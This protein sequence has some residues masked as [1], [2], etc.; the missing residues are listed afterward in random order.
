MGSMPQGRHQN[1]RQRVSYFTFDATLHDVSNAQ[2]QRVTWSQALTLAF[3][4]R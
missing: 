2:F 4:T 1:A 3:I